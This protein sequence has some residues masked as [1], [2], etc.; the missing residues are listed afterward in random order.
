MSDFHKPSED[1]SM[2]WHMTAL[3]FYL[4]QRPIGTPI[5]AQLAEITQ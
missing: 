1:F 2:T 3:I 4:E 5:A